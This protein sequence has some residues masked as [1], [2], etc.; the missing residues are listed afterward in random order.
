MGNIFG[1]IGKENT[2]DIIISGLNQLSGKCESSGIVL[3]EE[4]KFTAVKTK[5]GASELASKI[6]KSEIPAA[7]GLAQC[8]EDL[9]YKASS[10]F[11]PPSFSELFA[12]CSDGEIENFEALVSQIQAPFPVASNED[13]ILAFLSVNG[14]KKGSALLQEVSELI[15]G[16]I[17]IAFISLKE[18]AI[19]CRGGL[20]KLIIGFSK[21]GCFV[22]SELSALTGFCEKYALLGENEFARLSKDKISFFDSRQKKIKKTFMSVPAQRLIL[23]EIPP[24]KELDNLPI[25]VKRTLGNFVENGEIKFDYL[26]FSNRYSEKINKI[27]VIGSNG[28]ISTAR[29]A[30]SLFETYFALTSVCK[31]PGEF[32]SSY[33]PLDKGTLVVAISKNGEERKIL[34]CCRKAKQHRAKI[35]ALTNNPFSALSRES[36]FPVFVPAERKSLEVSIFECVSN[37]LAL[38]LFSIYIGRKIQTVSPLYLGVSL[39][40]AEMLPGILSSIAGNVSIGENPALLIRE[41]EN[42]FVCGGD[43]FSDETAKFLRE[44]ANKNASAVSLDELT[45]YPQ[46]LLENSAL[47]ALFYDGENAR[48]FKTDLKKIK[49]SGAKIII[50]TSESAKENF[51]EY[52]NLITFADTLP[53][54]NPIPC[55][56]CAYKIALLAG[57]RENETRKEQSA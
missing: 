35:L 4:E 3:K 40:M 53:V 54:F 50:I 37:Y 23:S 52:E 24:E 57:V 26:K 44:K 55:L 12:V 51:T 27:I 15:R 17:N 49:N 19:Y 13:L 6:S 29:S 46:S 45:E 48:H 1:F 21:Y 7:A 16:D 43:S 30:V 14:N 11:A 31:A 22:S 10:V 33:S 8:C 42:V 47:L 32:L 20:K 39:K 28:S 2:K 5:G 25:A 38:S 36:D 56:A 9:R 18:E 34:K 41:S